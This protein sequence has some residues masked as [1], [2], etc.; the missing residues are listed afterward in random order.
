M[1]QERVRSQPDTKGMT[2]EE[3]LELQERLFASSHARFAAGQQ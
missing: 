2:E 1:L 3:L